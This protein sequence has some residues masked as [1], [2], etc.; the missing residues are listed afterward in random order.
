VNNLAGGAI[1][2]ASGGTGT[3]S[4]TG[5]GNFTNAGTVNF[6]LNGTGAGQFDVLA[7]A[8][9]A[10]LGVGGPQGIMNVSLVSGFTPTT[11]STFN[12]MT[13]ASHSQSFLTTSFP[14][15]AWTAAYN[16]AALQLTAP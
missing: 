10:S 8:G 15:G 1:T 16:L 11:G 4:I 2:I 13:Y 9:A 5:T 3:L 14:P 12:V 6:K 7:V